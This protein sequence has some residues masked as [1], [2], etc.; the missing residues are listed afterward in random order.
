MAIWKSFCL[1][2]SR[3]LRRTLNVYVP[4]CVDALR[5]ARD[6]AICAEFDAIIAPG[7]DQSG[8]DAVFV[9]ARKYWL[10]DRMIWKTLKET[11]MGGGYTCQSEQATLF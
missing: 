3:I 9:L 8:K 1:T 10:S 7:S 11:D 5:N 4:R 2:S 6:R